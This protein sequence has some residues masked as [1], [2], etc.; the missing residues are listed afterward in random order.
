VGG[1]ARGSSVL[2][3]LAVVN[4]TIGFLVPPPGRLGKTTLK[5]P[6]LDGLLVVVLVVEVVVE[7]VN[8]FV[9]AGVSRS[10]YPGGRRLGS[11]FSVIVVNGF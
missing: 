3:A 2:A 5:P 1:V 9:P 11:S 4:R 10:L 8:F 6:P 7:V